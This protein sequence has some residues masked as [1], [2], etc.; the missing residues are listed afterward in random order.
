MQENCFAKIIFT[1]NGKDYN[2][3]YQFTGTG[4]TEE[5]AELYFTSGN[6]S[7]DC[8][9]SSLLYSIYGEEI[10]QLPWDCGEEIK[11]KSIKIFFKK[12]TAHLN[13]LA[14]DNSFI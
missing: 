14:N 13:N 2:V 8:N 3:D 12:Q 5:T 6:Y 1:F 9:R 11:L 4:W 10:K 7:C